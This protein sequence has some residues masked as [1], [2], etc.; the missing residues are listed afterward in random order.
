MRKIY[1][2]PNISI[3]HFSFTQNIATHCA[4]VTNTGNSAGKHDFWDPTTCA[5]ITEFRGESIR[6]WLTTTGTCT[7]S[8]ESTDSFDY[9]CYNQPEG[10]VTVFSS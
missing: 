6:I 3:E 7:D 1:K 4:G 8:Q 9:L 5:W 2:K 10:A